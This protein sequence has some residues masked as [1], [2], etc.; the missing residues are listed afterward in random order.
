[1]ARERG[2]LTV[3]V[4]TKPFPSRAPPHALADAGIAELQRYVDTLIVIPNQNLFRIANE[5]TTFAEAFA[6]ADRC[7][8]R[9]CAASPT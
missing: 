9:A 8:I 4:V 2:I 6:M 1:M 3:G 5:R 7:C